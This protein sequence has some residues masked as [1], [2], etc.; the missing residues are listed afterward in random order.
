MRTETINI[1]KIGEHPSKDKCFEWIRKNYLDK[2][3]PEIEDLVCS[4]KKLSE[5][6]GGTVD[7]AISH[8]DTQSDHITF[9]DYDEELLQGLNPD[10]CPLTG[11]FWDIE[12]IE[13]LR[14]KE[15]RQVLNTLYNCIEHL[16]TDEALI[17]MCG[18]NEYE[19][20][21]NGERV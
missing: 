5:V 6:I 4:I 17:E 14:E 2:G 18:D 21:E 1:Y 8:Y 20:Y 15:L 9:K 3:D 19:F 12:L 11:C 10:E 13:S 7:W 16:Y